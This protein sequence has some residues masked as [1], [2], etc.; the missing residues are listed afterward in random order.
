MG[1]DMDKKKMV[2]DLAIARFAKT[3]TI[4]ITQFNFYCAFLK[5]YRIRLCGT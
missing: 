3:K 5:I 2:R 1:S 4:S